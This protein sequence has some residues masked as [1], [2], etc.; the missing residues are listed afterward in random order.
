MVFAKY[1]DL[2]KDSC[3]GIKEFVTWQKIVSLPIFS[4][5]SLNFGDSWENFG[6]WRNSFALEM[7]SCWQ[8]FLHNKQFCLVQTGPKHLTITLQI[9]LGGFILLVVWYTV[10]STQQP[11]LIRKEQT[12]HYEERTEQKWVSA[13]INNRGHSE[14]KAIVKG[15]RGIGRGST[16]QALLDVLYTSY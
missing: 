10:F 12:G 11:P 9:R 8:I 2:T 15:V 1:N 16:A 3:Q 6:C 14:E 4:M 13:R 7:A 5:A